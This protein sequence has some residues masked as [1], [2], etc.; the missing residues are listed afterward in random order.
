MKFAGLQQWMMQVDENPSALKYNSKCS[1][2]ANQVQWNIRR[3]N[4]EVN[5]GVIVR[6]ANSIC[7]S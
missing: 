1:K 7:I 5:L 4:Q 3:P 6:N 2:R